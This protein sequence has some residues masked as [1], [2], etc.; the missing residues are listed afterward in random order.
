M[1]LYY[2]SSS[3]GYGAEFGTV[4]GIGNYAEGPYS[5]GWPWGFTSGSRGSSGSGVHVKNNA[6]AAW[7]RSA[8]TDARVYYNSY[9]AGVY[10]IICHSTIR[11]LVRTKNDNASQ[12]WWDQPSVCG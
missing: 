4:V 6:A 7:N 1:C 5:D 2:N 8:N 10:D 11:N 12:G 9:H 3:Y